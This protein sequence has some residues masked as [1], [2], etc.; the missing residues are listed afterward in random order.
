MRK[1]KNENRIGWAILFTLILAA[2][3]AGAG[4]AQQ[5]PPPDRFVDVPTDHWAYQAVENLRKEGIIVG[6]PDARLRGKRTVT[7]YEAAVGLDRF[8][9][10]AT[11]K[12]PQR[13]STAIPGARGPAGPSGAQGPTGI[14]PPEA[15]LLR[16]LID[17]LRQETS[18]LRARIAESESQA[19]RVQKEI[20]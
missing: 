17:Q 12:I 15:D 6:Y 20:R 7:R 1:T 2:G 13:R 11:S 4:N 5:Q 3:I 16:A 14:R 9:R 18:D 19:N 10:Q 8:Y